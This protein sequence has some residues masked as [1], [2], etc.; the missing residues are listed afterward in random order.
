MARAKSSADWTPAYRAR[1]ERVFKANPYA[2]KTE[3]R[4]GVN[5]K[6]ARAEHKGDKVHWQERAIG[7]AKAKLSN[8]KLRGELNVMTQAEVKRTESILEEI[9][10]LQK[11]KFETA[12]AGTRKDRDLQLEISKRYHLLEGEGII[13]DKSVDPFG[14]IYYKDGGD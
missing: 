2:T 9:I 12:V 1:M 14:K 13:G 4:R 11:E 5:S 10:K 7:D 8:V 3:A 6:E